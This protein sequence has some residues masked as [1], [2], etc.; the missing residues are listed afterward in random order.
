MGHKWYTSTIYGMPVESL[1]MH[2]SSMDISIV[3][4]NTLMDSQE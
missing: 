1:L 2:H 4:P 3:C